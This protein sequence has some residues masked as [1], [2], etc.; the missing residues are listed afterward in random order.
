[1]LP[2]AAHNVIDL[3]EVCE[4]MLPQVGGPD[5]AEDHRGCGVQPLGQPRDVDPAP[6]VGVQNGK[7]DDVGF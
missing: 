5:A 2:L 4:K 7:P 3:G 6:A 1:M